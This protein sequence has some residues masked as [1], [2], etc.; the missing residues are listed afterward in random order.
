MQEK[1]KRLDGASV[2]SSRI[3]RY[4]T[5]GRNFATNPPLHYHGSGNPDA[6]KEA[7]RARRPSVPRHVRANSPA[8]AS[9]VSAPAEAATRPASSLRRAKHANMQCIGCALVRVIPSSTVLSPSCTV[10]ASRDDLSTWSP[11]GRPRWQHSWLVFTLHRKRAW[12]EN[13][14]RL[15]QGLKFLTMVQADLVGSTSLTSQRSKPRS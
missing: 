11:P 6:L 12:P 7:V 15:V 1:N 9:L 2:R 8:P 3:S 13:L 5:T 10:C 4:S 14:H